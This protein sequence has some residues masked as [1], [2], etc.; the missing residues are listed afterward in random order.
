MRRKAET[1]GR[2]QGKRMSVER[3]LLRQMLLPLVGG[4]LGAK[5]TLYGLVQQMGILV[6]EEAFRE[7]AE[8]LVGVRGRHR[9]DRQFYH[10]G[11][12]LTRFPFAGRTVA[13]RRPRVRGLDGYEERLPLVEELRSLDPVCE[14][15]MDQI[16]LGVSTRG[17]GRSL[18]PLPAELRGRGTSKSTTSRHVVERTSARVAEFLSR[19][20]EEIDLAALMVDGLGVADSTVVVAVGIDTTGNKHPLGLWLGSTEN[21]ELCVALLHNL[22]D[23]G[24]TLPG[25][26]LAVIDGAKGLRKALDAVFGNAVVVQRCQ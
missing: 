23:R 3:V 1:R 7:D 12:T 4:V 5:E 6:M 20:L 26:L 17:Y 19:R 18:G 13:L 14:R 15:V 10:W 16:L 22:L 8:K 2:K 21:T 9:R 25:R 11:T 24:L